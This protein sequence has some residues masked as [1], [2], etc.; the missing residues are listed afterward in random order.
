MNSSARNIDMSPVA[1]PSGA[2]WRMRWLVFFA[3]CVLPVTFGWSLTKVVSTLVVSNDSFTQILVV[4]LV[5]VFLVYES[6][7]K[8]FSETRF[9]WIPGTALLLPGAFFLISARINLWSLGWTNQATLFLLAAVLTWIGAFGLCFGMRAFRLARFPLFFLLLGVPI[10][11]PILSEI[12]AFLQKESADAAAFFFR[13]AGVPFFR[14]DLVFRLPGT[15]IRV[16]EECSGIRS[17]LALLITTILAAH[18]YLRTTWKRFLLCAVVVPLAVLKNGLR[19]A[20]LSTLAVYV[21]P[22]YLTGNLHRRGG[23]VFFLIALLPIALLLIVLQRGERA[24]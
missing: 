12:V 4:P 8:V 13:L 24:T 9:A 14:Q 18:L 7:R 22:D 20:T 3:I 19:I 21:N 2:A 1:V 15:A 16:A 17:S 11:E 23:F 5:S 6:R 10:P